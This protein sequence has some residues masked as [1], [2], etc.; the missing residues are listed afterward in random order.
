MSETAASA[1]IPYVRTVEGAKFVGYVSDPSGSWICAAMN[2]RFIRLYQFQD[3]RRNYS[4]VYGE[5]FSW[6]ASF[7]KDPLDPTYLGHAQVAHGTPWDAL[8]YF[9]GWTS[10]IDQLIADGA[11]ADDILAAQTPAPIDEWTMPEDSEEDEDE[12]ESASVTV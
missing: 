6:Y 9:S 2:G 4:G 10:H 1:Y 12:D 5:G 3:E 11:S 7:D 8:E